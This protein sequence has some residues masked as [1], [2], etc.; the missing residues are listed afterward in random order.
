MPLGGKPVLQHALDALQPHFARAMIV[1]NTPDVYA[2]FRVPMVPDTIPGGAAMSGLHAALQAATTPAVFVCACDMPF[3]SAALVRFLAGELGQRDA[4]VPLR[5]ARME[6][7]HAVYTRF[8]LPALE[9]ALRAGRF[10]LAAVL[11][12]LSVHFVTEAESAAHDPSLRS[13]WNVNTPE[14]F[15]QAEEQMT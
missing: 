12:E 13:F 4:V 7:L 2:P 8:C 15:V 10:K 3:L 5:R 6:P 9:E 14:D 11:D 1:T